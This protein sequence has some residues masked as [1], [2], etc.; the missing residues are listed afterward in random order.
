MNQWSMSRFSERKT[1]SVASFEMGERGNVDSIDTPSMVM[2]KKVSK[3][4]GSSKEK[5]REREEKVQM[6]RIQQE[7]EKERERVKERKDK[8]KPNKEKEKKKSF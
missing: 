8:R 7:R 5:W 1:K 6:K 4:K 2:W 3:W